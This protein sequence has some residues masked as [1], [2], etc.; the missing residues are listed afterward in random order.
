MQK[1]VLLLIAGLFAAVVKAVEIRGKIITNNVIDDVSKLSPSTRITLNGASSIVNVDKNGEFIF[2]NVEAGSY[3]LEVQSIDYLFPKLRVD[4][5]EDNHIHAT[6]TAVGL[7]W[8]QRGLALGYPLEI[9]AKAEAEYFV[10]RQGFNILGMFKNP[11]FLMVGFS[12]LMMLVMPKMMNS[13]K[14]MDPDAADD[15][16]E[17]R[18]QAEKMLSD[19]PSL[20][21][22][23]AKR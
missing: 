13:L 19:M 9:Q 11:M 3:L 14:N 22:M 2:P 5:K 16:N 7:D 18:S 6:Y 1:L 12:G 23:F 20:Q 4:V 15:V 10:H 21:Q 17:S 8:N